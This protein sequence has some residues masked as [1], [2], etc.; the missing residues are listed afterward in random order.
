MAML[1]LFE[2][3]RVSSRI[4]FNVDGGA[5][6]SVYNGCEHQHS[7][8]EPKV[9]QQAK[10]AF[11]QCKAMAEDP[12]LQGPSKL[13]A[14][15]IDAML[16]VPEVQDEVA[17]ALEEFKSIMRDPV[18]QQRLNHFAEQI[19]AL[20][21]HPK[22]LM[23]AK[24]AAER[25]HDR[26]TMEDR[27][28]WKHAKLASEQLKAILQGPLLQ[29]HSKAFVERMQSAM[30][31]SKVQQHAKLAS[32]QLKAVMENPISQ[33]ISKPFAELKEA[34][35]THPQIKQHLLMEAISSNQADVTNGGASSLVQASGKF[36]PAPKQFTTRRYIP[37]HLPS[38]GR[39]AT[40]H[41]MGSDPSPVLGRSAGAALPRPLAAVRKSTALKHQVIGTDASVQHLTSAN[42]VAA[43]LT[44]T[45]ATRHLEAARAVA[46]LGVSGALDSGPLAGDQ[47]G[48][49]GAGK[50]LRINDLTRTQTQRPLA[51]DQPGGKSAG[52]LLRINDLRRTRTQ[53]M[54]LGVVPEMDMKEWI[55]VHKSIHP[56]RL[57]FLGQE[58]DD[59][60]CNHIIAQMLYYDTE[61]STE[62]Q[63]LYINSP[64]GSV[65]AGLAVYDTMQHV[66]SPV[67]TGT[68][69]FAASMSSF[70]LGAGVRGKR[71][72]LS[73]SRVM[74]HSP[75][76]GNNF[77]KSGA[78]D[79]RVEAD[80]IYHIKDTVISLYAEMTGRTRMQMQQDL[81]R[82]NYMSAQEAADY[83]LVDE[84]LPND[85]L[86]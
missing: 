26:V 10:L 16:T 22:V 28:V 36:I 31:V 52:K 64:G 14:G 25:R 40:M 8:T 47:P 38:R 62:S 78:E 67:I 70:L 34:V 17:H 45:A 79:P 69:G 4:R 20:G 59:D 30:A 61:D 15:Q 21:T 44:A 80:Q 39:A 9:M 12:D 56:H 5:V 48:G 6:E 82:D 73:D 55:E 35:M 85:L 23:H 66:S 51:G 86:G 1:S 24:N 76:S 3:R 53:M 18:I 46:V 75:L 84:I 72:A 49:K 54:A 37:L 68:L 32:E 58:I 71:F 81:E 33:N 2:G 60:I 19:N 57:S 43:A 29:E 83:G 77:E 7:A 42:K 74:V 27:D 65:I 11:D 63:Y 50:L 41:L 13:F